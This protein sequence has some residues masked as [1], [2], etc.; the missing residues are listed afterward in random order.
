MLEKEKIV[1]KLENGLNLFITGGA[2]SGKSYLLRELKHHFKRDISLTASTGIAAINIGGMTIHSFAKLGLGTDSLQKITS[3]ILK[4]KKSESRILK[5]KI[6]AIDEISMLSARFLN[7]LNDV[8]KIV[9]RNSAPFGGATVVFFGDFMQLPPVLKQDVEDSVALDSNTWRE[10]EIETIL[11]TYNYRQKDDSEFFRILKSIRLG[12]DIKDTYL[13]LQTRVGIKPLQNTIKLVSHKNQAF[14]INSSKLSSLPFEE[15]VFKGAFSGKEEYIK[16]Y[17]PHFE[18]RMELKLKKGA[19]VMLNWNI[20]ID[21]GLCNGT[22]GNVID[23]ALGTGFPIVLFENVK[24]PLVV[25]CNDFT[26]E[27][28]ITSEIL[29][30]FTQI[31]LQLAYSLT[32]HKSQGLTFDYIETDISKCFLE[33]QAYVSLSRA[34]SMDGLFLYPFPISALRANSKLALYYENLENLALKV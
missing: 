13:K 17:G 33:G 22:V 16:L 6:L 29:F 11:L 3:K 9:R 24:A 25:S 20:N 8:F 21:A 28:Q 30:R 18:E 23:F 5:C 10:A 31:P 19:R 14:E 32:I 26:I 15:K 27:D 2:G 1:K 34:R 12:K 4:D 7:L